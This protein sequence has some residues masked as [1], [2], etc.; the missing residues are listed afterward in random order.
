MEACKK[1]WEAGV[2]HPDTLLPYPRNVVPFFSDFLENFET[3]SV[4]LDG[5]KK[6]GSKNRVCW[7]KKQ[8]GCFLKEGYGI[9]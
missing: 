6:R 1:L 9:Y 7:Y 5:E 3:K 4:V 2:L 8:V